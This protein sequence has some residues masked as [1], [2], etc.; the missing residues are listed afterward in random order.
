MSSYYSVFIIA[1]IVR[2]LPCL[3]RKKSHH[4]IL[5]KIYIAVIFIILFI[6]KKVC[7]TFA[8]FI[9]HTGSP[10]DELSLLLS[11]GVLLEATSDEL[12]EVELSLSVEL[13]VSLL[14]TSLLVCSL[15]LLVS[16]LT[17]SEE[18]SL[19][20]ELELIVELVSVVVFCELVTVDEVEVVLLVDTVEEVSFEEDEL[21]EEDDGLLLVLGLL[22]E[23]L[24]LELGDQP[25]LL[26]Y[27]SF[28]S[29]PFCSI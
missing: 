17:I 24:G 3:I 16:L 20:L 11:C 10:E 27:Q 25:I 7:A 5:I 8:H 4:F 15:L 28:F 22:D 26:A 1:V 6:I 14:V 9:A 29:I 2:T 13:V 21:E 23:V 19:S 12:E 18:T